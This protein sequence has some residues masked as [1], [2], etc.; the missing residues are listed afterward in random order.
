MPTIRKRYWVTAVVV[1]VV[2]AAV[3]WW[4]RPLP[5]AGPWQA[6]ILDADTG[7]PLEGV[8]VL[9]LWEKRTFA[10]PH[11]DRGYHDLDEVVSDKDGRIVIPARVVASRHPFEITLGPLL[12]IFK[13]GYG[14][15]HF[16]GMPEAW[17]KDPEAA[18]QRSDEIWYRFGHGGAVMVMPRAKTREE[19]KEIVRVIF[20]DAEVPSVKYPRFLDAYNQERVSLGFSR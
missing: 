2:A 18:R 20:P 11:P 4:L 8:I 1:L 16:E 7:Q 13:P 17:K 19:R 9:A 6:Q 5:L 10:W 12:T 15:W 3:A 14:K